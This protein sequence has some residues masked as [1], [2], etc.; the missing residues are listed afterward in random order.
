MSFQFGAQATASGQLR[1]GSCGQLRAAFGSGVVVGTRRK[2]SRRAGGG[3]EA[4]GRVR[5]GEG[6]AQNGSRG[7]KL[8][9]AGPAG[10]SRARPPPQRR[11]PAGAGGLLARAGK[12]PTSVGKS[13]P[14]LAACACASLLVLVLLRHKL[15]LCVRLCLCAC[16]CARRKVGLSCSCAPK[17]GPQRPAQFAQLP[18]EG[19][20]KAC[21]PAP[22]RLLALGSSL[23]GLLSLTGGLFQ[24]DCQQ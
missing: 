1:A 10:G 16:A 4:A 18:S 11:L 23:A 19:A 7:A 20:P 14:L 17:G 24:L 9:L 12:P 22:R 8:R 6:G 21:A 15:C 2:G 5:R 13:R 3:Q